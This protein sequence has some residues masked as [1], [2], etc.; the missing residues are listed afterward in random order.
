MLNFIF[1]VLIIVSIVFYLYYKTKQFR[2]TLPIQS[3]WY[4]S[5]AS[6]TLGVLVASFGLNQVLLFHSTLTYIIAALFI[7]LGAAMAFSNFKAA[8]HYR[9]FLAEEIELNK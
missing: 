3:K 9:Q 8:K 4:K 1:V 5:M 6:A 2:T 7:L